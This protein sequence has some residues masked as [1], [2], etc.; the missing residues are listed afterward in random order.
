MCGKVIALCLA[1][2][3]PMIPQLFPLGAAKVCRGH[4]AVVSSRPRVLQWED[5]SKV[6][7]HNPPAPVVLC[8]HHHNKKESSLTPVDSTSQE[9]LRPG[10]NFIFEE[11]VCAT[12]SL[13]E[14]GSSADP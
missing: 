14:F 11:A 4:R 10:Q 2:N 6:R 3:P 13:A 1:Q 9:F 5:A 12:V 7:L 8:G